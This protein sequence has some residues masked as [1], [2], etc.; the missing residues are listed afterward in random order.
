MT[1]YKNLWIEKYRPKTL[2]DLCISDDIKGLIVGWGD[3]IPHLLL[4]GHAGVGKTTLSRI[5]VEDLLKC[6]FLYINASD[7]NGIDTIRNKVT[8]F[9]QTKSLDGNLKVV[10]LDEADGL[11]IDG[12]KCLRNLMESY[13]NTARF[14]LTGNHRHKISTALQSRCQSLDLRPDLRSAVG[15]CLHILDKEGI[16]INKEQAQQVVDLVKQNFPDLRKCIGELSKNCVGGVFKLVKKESTDELL[17]LIWKNLKSKKGLDTRKY[18]I[19]NDALFNSDWDQLLTNLLNYVYV[20]RIEDAN[21]KAMV[22][23]IADYLDKTTRVAD[24]E[25]NFFA[26]ILSLEDYA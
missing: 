19:E 15:R 20:Q 16:K 21:K 26:C 3:D 22:I 23:T 17:N 24:K 9:V 25:I 4:I 14:I 2:E 8:G 5:L 13:A 6:D 1:Q 7:E 18:L 11:T 10:I 12:Q